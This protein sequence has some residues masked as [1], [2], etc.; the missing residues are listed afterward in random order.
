MSPDQKPQSKRSGGK[1]KSPV[2][3]PSAAGKSTPPLKNVPKEFGVVRKGKVLVVHDENGQI[4]STTRVSPDSPYGV[5]V[6]PGPGQTVKEYE[7]EDL[8]DALEPS[9]S[10]A[11]PQSRA[12]KKARAGIESRQEKRKRG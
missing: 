3:R 8:R 5:G 12:G 2:S 6:K 10:K 9:G 7:A 4:V 11:R 1:H